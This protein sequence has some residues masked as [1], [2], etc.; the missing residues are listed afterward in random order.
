MF[1]FISYNV[2]HINLLSMEKAKNGLYHR[3][4]DEV[5]Y[6]HNHPNLNITSYS[7]LYLNSNLFVS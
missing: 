5:T 1:S 4:T 3:V 2:I 6:S 7:P